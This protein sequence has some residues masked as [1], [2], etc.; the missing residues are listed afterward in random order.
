M[1]QG[2]R[3]MVFVKDSNNVSF[4]GEYKGLQGLSSLVSVRTIWDPILEEMQQFIIT[5]TRNGYRK[6][7][8]HF[9][10]FKVEI[11]LQIMSDTIYKE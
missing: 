1:G 7:K 10:D 4:Y 5:I 3:F 9:E 11:I 8:F 2:A 6:R